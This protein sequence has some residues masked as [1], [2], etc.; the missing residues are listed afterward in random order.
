MRGILA[1]AASGRVALPIY[2][3]PEVN[4][5]ADASARIRATAVKV[6][7]TEAF[8]IA[9]LWLLGRYFSA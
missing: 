7:V 5:S 3:G 6:L 1:G 4:V 2:C 9:A 8:V